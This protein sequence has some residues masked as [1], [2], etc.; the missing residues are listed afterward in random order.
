MGNLNPVSEITNPLDEL[1]LNI[2]E[3]FNGI[4][5][6]IFQFGTIILFLIY[7]GLG[8]NLL[9]TAKIN[10]DNERLNGINLEYLN[11]QGRIGT[12]LY[13]LVGF[14]FLFRVIP[15]VLLLCFE[16][17]SSSLFLDFLNSGQLFDNFIVSNG[18]LTVLESFLIQLT[19]MISFIGI[20]LLSIGIYLILFNKSILRT[21]YKPLSFFFLGMGL[22]I[23]FG[24]T[25]FLRLIL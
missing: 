12:I 23:L 22:L 9:R 10:E 13:I 19:G 3:G 4:S 8:L 20:I 14:G 17:F 5:I 1:F 6:K 18:T 16:P 25:P 24:I 2:A 7:L 21:R 11:K 15:L